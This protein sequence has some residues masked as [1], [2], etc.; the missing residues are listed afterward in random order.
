MEIQ[1]D[2]F[3]YCVSDVCVDYIACSSSDEFF[4]DFVK[5]GKLDVYEEY[6]YYP[7]SFY[8]RLFKIDD[9]ELLMFFI[10]VS[11]LPSKF[12]RELLKLGDEKLIKSYFG[13]D[14]QCYTNKAAIHIF[15]EENADNINELLDSNC[16]IGYFGEAWLFKSGRNDYIKRYLENRNLTHFGEGCL[17]KYADKDI[18]LEYL[19]DEVILG[20]IAFVSAMERKD[21][22]IIKRMIE[23]IPYFYEEERQLEAFLL[24][25]SNDTITSFFENMDEREYASINIEVSKELAR[26]VFLTRDLNVQ[27]S[28]INWFDLSNEKLSN[29]LGEFAHRDIVI[30]Q[31]LRNDEFSCEVIKLIKRRDMGIIKAFL[32]EN[33]FKSEDEEMEFILLMD[34]NMIL[35]YA[36]KI[37]FSYLDIS[38]IDEI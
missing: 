18:V 15:E 16:S 24:N 19:N 34:E 37:G 30:E 3:G 38:I 7:D 13:E 26:K 29:V 35:E 28:F 32:K 27:K 4:R 11:F 2:S 8:E 17:I 21:K 6:Y 20:N 33:K 36:E 14:K 12:E 5:L 22:D 9:K 23:L 1:L 10:K 31:I 25:A